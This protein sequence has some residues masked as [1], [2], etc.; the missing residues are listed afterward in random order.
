VVGGEFERKDALTIVVA[1]NLLYTNITFPCFA[2][3]D[4]FARSR[5]RDAIRSTWSLFWT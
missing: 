5:L 3:C 2:E 1:Y 4:H